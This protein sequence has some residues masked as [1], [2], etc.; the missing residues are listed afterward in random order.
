MAIYTTET[1]FGI[2]E[3][4]ATLVLPLNDGDST[5]EYTGYALSK[6][7]FFS[8]YVTVQTAVVDGI[9]TDAEFL[10]I[11]TTFFGPTQTTAIVDFSNT[12]SAK[13]VILKALLS[14]LAGIIKKKDFA[15]I[16]ALGVIL[17]PTY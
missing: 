5:I 8:N 11:I 7:V 13:A 4:Y 9:A 10:A 3:N 12:W 15:E 6:A 17:E 1:V 2:Q 14:K 16:V